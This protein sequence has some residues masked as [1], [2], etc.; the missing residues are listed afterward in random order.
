M[1]TT[2]YQAVTGLLFLLLIWAA[3]MFY[4]NPSWALAMLLP[5]LAWLIFDPL[6]MAL[7]NKLGEG[8]MLYVLTWLRY[9]LRV[10]AMPFLLIVAFDQVRRA[11]V[12][13]ASDPLASLGVWVVALVLVALGFVR[14]FWGGFGME[15]TELDGIKQYKEVE[16][17]GLPI[18]A[19]ITL[20]II[21]LFG[22]LAFMKTRSPWLL[23]GA[24]AWLMAIILPATMI[25]SVLAA[26]ASAFFVIGVLL[27]ESSVRQISPNPRQ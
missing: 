5:L 24:L 25:P 21:T 3:V 7:G 4:K 20:A 11:R 14:A 2:L 10:L 23:L 1:A 6:V 12:D 27:S 18:A 8:S 15:I 22:V 13:W 17:I 9:V 19:I 16:A 26:V